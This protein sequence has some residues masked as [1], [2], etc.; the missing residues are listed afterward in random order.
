MTLR[1]LTVILVLTAYSADAGELRGVVRSAAEGT[2]LAGA[3]IRIAGSQRGT[4]TKQ[5]GT[6]ALVVPDSVERVAVRVGAFGYFDKTDTLFAGRVNT[7][8]LIARSFQSGEVIVRGQRGNTFGFSQVEPVQSAALY[9]AKKSELIIPDNI[10][11]NTATNNARQVFARVAGLNIW[12]SDQAGLQLG[13]GGRGLSPNRTAH[14]NTR[15]NGYDISA[16]ALGYPESY[17]TPPVEALERI[18][19]IRGAASLQYG[20]QFGGLLNFVMKSGSDTLPFQATHRLT[21][22]SFGFVN[23]FN[24][25]GGTAGGVQYYGV[26]QFKRGDGWRPNSGFTSHTAYGALRFQPASNLALGIE[27]TRFQYTAQQPG[28]LTDVMFA[29]NPQQSV[30]ARNWF[31]VHWNIL[32][33]TLDWSITPSLKLNSRTFSVLSDRTAVGNLERIN[34][35]DFENR[36]RTVIRGDFTNIGNETRLLWTTEVFG[37]PA[38]ILAGVRAYWGSTIQ[39]QGDGTNGRDANFSLLNP[40]N[41]ENSWYD[42]PSRNI[43]VFTEQIFRITPQLSIVPGIRFERIATFSKGWYNN[44]VFDF[45]GNLISQTRVDESRENVRSLLLAGLGIGYRAS[46]EAELYA[47]ISQNYR[48]VNFSDMRITNPNFQIDQNLTDERGWTADLGI[49][50]SLRD[51]LYYD[52][53]VFALRYADRIGLLLRSDEPPLY[54]P[55]RYRT[56]IGSSQTYGI[57]AFAEADVLKMMDSAATSSVTVFANISALRGT[58]IASANTAIIGN[59]VELVPPLILRT[60]INY[61]SGNLRIGAQWSHTYRHYTDATNAERTS[62][63]V[64][65]IIPAYSVLDVSARYALSDF[66]ALELSCNNATDARYFTRRADGYPGPGIIPADARQFYGGIEVRW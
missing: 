7:V 61:R 28:G 31:S 8:R 2:P 45:A 5:N 47:N 50:G 18:E 62:T 63:A 23:S 12:E 25:V 54:L 1:F 37:N 35:V 3:R 52:V 38:N 17:Y 46:D 53:S 44:R 33:A 41:P 19:V 11:A 20:T 49:R 26:Y 39:K 40:T 65:G 43:A 66:L 9:E 15:Q 64:N 58:Y 24:S 29:D 55:Y 51:I 30:R 27:A 16:D 10:S 22:G 21:G 48:A 42:T 56:N 32:A 36:N 34:V 59:E 57:E 6:F 4:V 14:F 60:G 13:V